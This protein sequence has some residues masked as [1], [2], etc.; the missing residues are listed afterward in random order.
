MGKKQELT[1]LEKL[2]NEHLPE[3]IAARLDAKPEHSYLGDAV[4]G[5]IDGSVTTF[6]VVAG[7]VGASL[8]SSVVIILGLANL[9]ADGFS[10]A[11]SNY[12]KSKSERQRTEK[13]RSIEATH[14]EHHPEG[15]KEEIRQI[16]E[17]KGFEGPLLDEIVAVITKD[18]DRW[19]NTMLTEELGVPLEAPEPMKAAWTTFLAFSI[20]GAIPLVPFLL[21]LRF[22]VTNLFF[23]SALATAIS[24]FLVGCMKGRVLSHSIFKSGVETLLTGGLAASLAYIVGWWLRSLV[25]A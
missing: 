4:L 21:A 3:I 24:F 14:I 16:F 2:R 17:R 13:L 19:I 9:F 15:E 18:K 1:E 5:A 6:A 20:A 8:S 25:E 22:S 7:V 10:M 23:W 11:A 12:Q